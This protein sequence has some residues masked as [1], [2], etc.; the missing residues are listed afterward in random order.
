MILKLM[1][2][3]TEGKTYNLGDQRYEIKIKDLVVK[4]AQ[5]LKQKKI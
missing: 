1:T 5:I 4:I 3:N 2:K